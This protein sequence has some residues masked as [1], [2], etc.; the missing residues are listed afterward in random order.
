MWNFEYNTGLIL[1]FLNRGFSKEI[2]SI[3]PGINAYWGLSLTVVLWIKWA[4]DPMRHLMDG[5]M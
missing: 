3:N 1:V 4:I 5:D 2:T